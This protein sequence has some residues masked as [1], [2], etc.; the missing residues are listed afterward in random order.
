MLEKIIPI[1]RFTILLSA[2]LM[3]VGM[4]SSCEK[5]EED[6]ENRDAFLGQWDVVENEAGINPVSVELRSINDVHIVNIT[7]S[8]VF[9]DEVN[10]YNFSALGD[11]FRVPAYVEGKNITIPEITLDGNDIKGSGT[12]SSNNKTIEWTYWLDM[13]GTNVEYRAT[14]TLRE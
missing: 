13:D 1:K 12:I 5:N 6:M 11:G 7:R 2:T 14:Y 4:L 9:A 8:E 3:L 10:I